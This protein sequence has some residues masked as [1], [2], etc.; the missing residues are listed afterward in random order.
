MLPENR[1]LK[2][3]EKS[4]NAPSGQSTL[5]SSVYCPNSSKLSKQMIRYENMVSHCEK[6]QNATSCV[7]NK[8]PVSMMSSQKVRER[9]QRTKKDD[10]NILNKSILLKLKTN[11]SESKTTDPSTSLAVL[12]NTTSTS[13]DKSTKNNENTTND[14]SVVSD[15]SRIRNLKQSLRLNQPQI[16]YYKAMLKKHNQVELSSNRQRVL[17]TIKGG[18]ISGD[19]IEKRS[20]LFTEKNTFSPRI[21]NTNAKSRLAQSSFY[22]APNKNINKDQDQMTAYFGDLNMDDTLKDSTAKEPNV[23]GLVPRLDISRD[24]DNQK[25]LNNK[26]MKRNDATLKPLSNMRLTKST[27]TNTHNKIKK[28]KN[29]SKSEY[30]YS[31]PRHSSDQDKLNMTLRRSELDDLSFSFMRDSA[32]DLQISKLYIIINYLYL[33]IEKLREITEKV[34]E[35]LGIPNSEYSDDSNLGVCYTPHKYR[36]I[37]KD[38][39]KETE[40]TDY[41]ETDDCSSVKSS[42]KNKLKLEQRIQ[43][44]DSSEH[45][46]CFVKSQSEKL[47]NI[48][49]KPKS[50]QNS[51]AIMKTNQRQ[52]SPETTELV[53]QNITNNTDDFSSD[54]WMSQF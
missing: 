50:N 14:G 53:N 32:S 28:L 17:E 15:L 52:S 38:L 42:F 9:L 35:A 26:N 39:K 18:K 4:L 11:S 12:S 19:V 54:D 20:N 27:N 8:T 3:Y 10:S 46:Q 48:S 40:K 5:K 22:Q 25:W 49:E 7:D 34:K 16:N 37:K 13:K 44:S 24:K 6:I 43:H 2:P 33:Q 1:K 29:R 30:E 31:T 51:K 21:L 45:S 23:N 41:S 47:P 36:K